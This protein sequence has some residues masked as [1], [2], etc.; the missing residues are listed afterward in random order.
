MTV[1]E[2]IKMVRESRGLTQAE[3]AARIG[4][5]RDII[6][7]TEKGRTR[8]TEPTLREIARQFAVD[9]N[10]LRTGEGDIDTPTKPAAEMST[11]GLLANLVNGSA[12]PE[13]QLLV[14]WIATATETELRAVVNAAERLIAMRDNK[15]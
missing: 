6:S 10:W 4:T 2:R 13:A 3:F 15:E 11:L 12:S 9:L 1:G 7:N 8:A 14:Q 5:T